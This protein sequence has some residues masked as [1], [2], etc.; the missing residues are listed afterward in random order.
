MMRRQNALGV[1]AGLLLAACGT[2][3]TSTATFADARDGVARLR[4]AL[5]TSGAAAMPMGQGNGN[6]HQVALDEAIVTIDRVTV[7]SSSVGW[8]TLRDSINVAVDVLRL[9]DH[10]AELGFADLPT[11]RINQIRLHVDGASPPYVTTADGE[12]VPLKVPSGEQSGL[13]VKGNWEL[14]DCAETTIDLQLDGKKAIWIHP[15]GHGDLYILRPTIKAGSSVIPGECDGTPDNGIPPGELEPMTDPIP[16]G[17]D[18]GT[19][20]NTDPATDPNDVIDPPPSGNGAPCSGNL[21]CGVTEI[22]GSDGTC[23]GL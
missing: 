22:C 2:D 8:V 4:V 5:S 19:D 9:G 16:G 23:M 7:H 18:P 6:K 13:K 11:G 1:G 3:S 15:T 17:E 14:D 10:A 20:P 21:D 12:R